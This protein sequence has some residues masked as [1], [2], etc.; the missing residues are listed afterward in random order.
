MAEAGIMTA[1]TKGRWVAAMLAGVLAVPAVPLAADGAREG[2]ADERVI[3]CE[4]RN[5]RYRYCRAD[6]DNRASLVSQTSPFA[7]CELGRTW[8]YDNRGVW[9]DRGCAGEFRVGRGGGGGAGTAAAVGAIAGAAVLAAIIAQKSHDSHRDE[10]PAWAVGTF[11]GHD[12]REG[13]DIEVRIS[14]SGSADGQANGERFT[15]RYAKDRLELARY[16]FRVTRSGNGFNAVDE[17]DGAHRIFFS[18]A[19][20]GWGQ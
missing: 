10:V 17:G 2:G 4:S 3:R 1:L 6:T 14:P 9:V 5:Y 11:R 12:E 13:V 18:P 15:G 8:G 16:R 7:R 19:G 20:S